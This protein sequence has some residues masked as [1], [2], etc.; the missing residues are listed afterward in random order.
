MRRYLKINGLESKIH[1]FCK[2]VGTPGKRELY[3]NPKNS[4]MGTFDKISSETQRVDIIGIKEVF[5]DIPHCDLL[6]IDC[7]GAEYEFIFDTPFEKIDQISM[8]L[9]KG[10]QRKVL[11]HL[12]KF[13]NTH[14]KQAIDG[15]SLMVFCFKK[16]Q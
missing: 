7:E 10:E 6:K 9:H 11:N 3:L 2:G 8:E 16:K 15:T 12:E 1:C 13:Y 14:T 4:G 5:K